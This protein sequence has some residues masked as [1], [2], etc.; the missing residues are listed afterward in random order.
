VANDR[1]LKSPLVGKFLLTVEMDIISIS[2]SSQHFESASTFWIQLSIFDA[3]PAP[4]PP[5]LSTKKQKKSPK[6]FL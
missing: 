5:F 3:D 2:M 1:F 6:K 4:N